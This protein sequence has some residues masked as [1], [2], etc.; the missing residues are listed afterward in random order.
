MFFMA[1]LVCLCLCVLPTARGRG[2]TGDTHN[3]IS[4]Y[5][6]RVLISSNVHSHG[7]TLL[8]SLKC[9]KRKH[10]VRAAFMVAAAAKVIIGLRLHWE[11]P[12]NTKISVLNSPNCL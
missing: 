4:Q 8:R 1:Q 12:V 2:H 5:T 9:E 6:E 7:A 10:T 11:K 3:F